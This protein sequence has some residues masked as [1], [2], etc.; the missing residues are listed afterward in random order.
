MGASQAG[1]SGCKGCRKVGAARRA[2]GWGGNARF[3]ALEGLWLSFFPGARC[4]FSA[5]ILQKEVRRVFSVSPTEEEIEAE[6]K[7]QALSTHP[8]LGPLSPPAAFP[9]DSGQGHLWGG[10]QVSAT[11]KLSRVSPGGGR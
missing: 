4:P 10:A 11:A 5:P 7:S 1:S 6:L 2:L 9:A 3:L 8:V